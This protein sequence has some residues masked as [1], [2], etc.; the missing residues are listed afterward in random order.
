MSTLGAKVTSLTAWQS[1]MKTVVST[2][3]IVGV[4]TA[5]MA[6]VPMRRA[7]YIEIALSGAMTGV[8]WSTIAEFTFNR[9]DTAD[10]KT[11]IILGNAGIGALTGVV[12]N[13][14]ISG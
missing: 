12:T 2:T 8:V 4:A 11:T 10:T 1:A 6:A 3:P 14:L 9:D 5:L 13:A 7:G